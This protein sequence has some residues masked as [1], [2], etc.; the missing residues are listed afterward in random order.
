[1]VNFQ[2]TISA[3]ASKGGTT[4]AGLEAM[5]SIEKALELATQRSRELGK[6]FGNAD[7]EE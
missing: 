2:E 6:E 5:P 7:S 4:E 1:M 3:I